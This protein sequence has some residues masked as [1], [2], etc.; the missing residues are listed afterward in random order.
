MLFTGINLEDTTQVT[1]LR[2]SV[3]RFVPVDHL[4]HLSYTLGYR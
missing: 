1:G 3:S 2:P 4:E